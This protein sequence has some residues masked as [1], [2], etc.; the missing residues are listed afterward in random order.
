MST[1]DEV[2]TPEGAAMLKRVLD[3]KGRIV[4]QFSCG[5]ASAVATKLT[6]ANY[7]HDGLV[8]VNV[9]IQEEH[10]DNRRFLA[11]C[12][13]WF[14]H[15]ITVL[16]ND[17]YNASTHEIWKRKRYI[18][19]HHKAPCSAELKRDLMVQVKSGEP[20]TATNEAAARMKFIQISLGAIYD[21]DHTAHA[22]D[23]KPRIEELKEILLQAPSKCLVFAPLT[24][25]IHLLYEELKAWSREIINGEVDASHNR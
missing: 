3:S 2:I 4:C 5:A 1:A 22:I 15:P 21:S 20:I 6:I 25:V 23:A 14:E 24:S 17:K 7:G 10:P 13:K 11:D 16:R 12:E 19:G 8:I 18:I 9:F